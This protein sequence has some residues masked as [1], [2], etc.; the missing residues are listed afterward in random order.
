MPEIYKQ[1]KLHIYRDINGNFNILFG[2]KDKPNGPD[3]GHYVITNIGEF[4]YHR[5]PDE[6]HGAHNF[7]NASLQTI[8]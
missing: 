6:P 2:G 5:N 8:F 4:F 1:E 7:E 3:H